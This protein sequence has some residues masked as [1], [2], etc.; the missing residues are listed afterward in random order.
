MKLSCKLCNNLWKNEKNIEC[1][2]TISKFNL[3]QV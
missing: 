1:F 2:Q 3:I